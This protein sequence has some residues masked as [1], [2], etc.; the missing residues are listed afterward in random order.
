MVHVVKRGDTLG[1]IAK[2][3]GT[4]LSEILAVNPQ[5]TNADLI[6]I[7]QQITI[8]G[9]G[10]GSDGPA[11]PRTD[12]GTAQP[13]P[14]VPP[15]SAPPK[16]TPKPKPK[17]APKK[18]PPGPTTGPAAPPSTHKVESGETMKVI[19]ARFGVSLTDLIAANPQVPNPDLIRKGQKLNLPA[20]SRAEQE[21]GTPAGPK[22]KPKPPARTTPPR[23]VRNWSRVPI[24]QRMLYAMER[25]VE[26]GYP[27]NGAAG[28]LG[29]LFVESGVIPNRLQGSSA[30]TPMRTRDFD[31]S[32]VDFA[33]EHVMGRDSASSAGPLLAG[34]GLAQWTSAKRRSRLFAH[35]FNGLVLGPRD[36]VRHGRPARL[37]RHR[38]PQGLS[39]GTRDPRRPDA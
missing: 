26:R 27:L 25:L 12:T 22:P 21:T 15:V 28:I 32:L 14:K 1:K 35:E 19:A 31:G 9:N 6:S 8:P 20:G 24:D 36:L 10:A 23:R 5:I 4:T 7:D 37:S 34:V 30:R 13:K 16:P 33:P 2:E 39:R 38:A 3:H 18:P 17:V 29:N 11:P